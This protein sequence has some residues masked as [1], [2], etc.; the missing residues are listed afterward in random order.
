[1]LSGPAESSHSRASQSAGHLS[2]HVDGHHPA[3]LPFLFEESHTRV[4]PA[5][6]ASFLW[7]ATFALFILLL[8]RGSAPGGATRA[9]LDNLSHPKIIW[10][11]DP[12]PG[13][14]GGGGGNHGDQPPRQVEMPGHD[15]MTLPVQ[16]PASIAMTGQREPDP[17]ERVNI[18]AQSFAAAQDW[19]PGAIETPAAPPT[20]SLGS[21]SGSGAGTGRGSGIGSG[22]GSGL[23]IGSGGNTGGQ[24]YQ[25]GS[26]VI[27]PRLLKEV[28][29]QY[30]ADAMRAKV[31]GTVVVACVVRPDGSV[32]DVRVLRSLDP[33]FGLDQQ[34]VVAA[35][36]W[37]FAP[38]TRMGTPVAVQITIELTF[39]LR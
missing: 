35:K 23:G 9:G 13:G 26:G 6:L 17:I 36:Q 22:D 2:V 33:N 12:G 28:K 4:A 14:G 15:R 32:G 27:T 16:R 30:T 21:G 10:F 5:A 19:I 20:T 25:P 1:M 18:P 31:Q 24:V 3:G 29:P 7:H 8:V 34:A 37:K 11:N 39:T 38:G